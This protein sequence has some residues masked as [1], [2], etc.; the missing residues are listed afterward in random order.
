[1]TLT[2]DTFLRDD[3]GSPLGRGMPGGRTLRADG[4]SHYEAWLALVRRDPCAYCPAPGAS[5]TVDHVDPRSRPARGLGSAHGW[6]NTVGACERCNGSKRDLDL[7]VFLHRRSRTGRKASSRRARDRGPS[8]VHCTTRA[9]GARHPR[10][11]ASSRTTTIV[12][13]AATPNTGS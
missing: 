7:L 6:I 12:A 13:A 4:E 2:L 1:M 3:P 8:A 9:V 5:G 10:R 11:R